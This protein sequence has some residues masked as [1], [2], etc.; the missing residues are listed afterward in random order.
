[1]KEWEENPKKLFHLFVFEERVN[2]AKWRHE[3]RM[4]MMRLRASSVRSTNTFTL[5]TPLQC[6]TYPSTVSYD[7]GNDEELTALGAGQRSG[8]VYA[9]GGARGRVDVWSMLTV[10]RAARPVV[11]LR[12]ATAD[13]GAV[14]ALAFDRDEEVLLAV[15]EHGGGTVTLW[16][17]ETQQ[18]ALE[19]ALVA[20]P[21]AGSHTTG[22]LCGAFSRS[23]ELVAC[24]GAGADGAPLVRLYDVRQRCAVATW[25]GAEALGGARVTALQFSP[26]GAWLVTGSAAGT[27]R[28]WDL[29]CTERALQ[30]HDLARHGAVAALDMRGSHAVVGSGDG[31]ATLLDLGHA[32]LL[33][34]SGG[35]GVPLHAVALAKKS[36]APGCSVYCLSADALEHH[37]LSED[38]DGGDSG[39]VVA[40]WRRDWGTLGTIS[41][42]AGAQC[43]VTSA[44]GTTV[45]IFTCSLSTPAV[46]PSGT[47][48]T[49][50]VQGNVGSAICRATPRKETRRKSLARELLV[51]R[52][53]TAEPETKR[54][55]QLASVPPQQHH[56]SKSSSEES[57][58]PPSEQL[59]QPPTT[60]ASLHIMQVSG[61]SSD[62]HADVVAM[63][64]DRERALRTVHE[65]CAR[66]DCAGAMAAAWES[67]DLVVVADFVAAAVVRH[68]QLFVTGAALRTFHAPAV[69]ALLGSPYPFLAE[70]GVKLLEAVVDCA[71]ETLSPSV[72]PAPRNPQLRVLHALRRRIAEMQS[73]G[74]T[75][76]PKRLPV[77]LERLDALLR[78][79]R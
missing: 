33:G 58:L 52:D 61:D 15:A 74:T 12:P 64:S 46:A 72:Q 56:S 38:E 21:D 27:V 55:R 4:T 40:T 66:G 36:A 41:L 50:V 62:M 16:D 10:Q 67:H 19:T 8:L 17:V 43:V 68:P 45:E 49:A 78:S 71:D 53:T 2:V 37:V 11:T 32:R 29:G 5:E 30:T 77:V 26:D 48:S 65:H 79:V 20:G 3:E 22:P 39:A 51:R 9:T 47:T 6:C 34:S 70:Q 76:L 7:T 69:V 59:P 35:G 28:V 24:A 75:L 31:A 14:R 73:S 42:P 54:P 23:G 44:R 63:L 18:A 25:E 60:V 57:L 1:M 13:A